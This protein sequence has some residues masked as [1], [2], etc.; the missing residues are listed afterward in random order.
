MFRRSTRLLQRVC[1]QLPYIRGRGLPSVLIQSVTDGY[2]ASILSEPGIAWCADSTGAG[3]YDG[4]SAELLHEVA[5]RSP[6][7]QPDLS[8]DP[9]HP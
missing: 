1:S 9:T 5:K 3:T 6:A 8:P 4:Q 7:P 2:V